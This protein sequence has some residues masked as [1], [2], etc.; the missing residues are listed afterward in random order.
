MVT[1][2]RGTKKPKLLEQINRDFL[3][4]IRGKSKDEAN[5]IWKSAKYNGKWNN[6]DTKN[7][8]EVINK[9]RCSFCTK[10]IDE[11]KIHFNVEHICLKSKYPE[12]A[13]QWD[14]L[15]CS[16]DICNRARG[17]ADIDLDLYIDPTSEK[18]VERYFEYD[19]DGSVKIN[20]GLNGKDRIKAKTMIEKYKLNRNDLKCERRY[21]I[22]ELYSEENFKV[23]FAQDHSKTFMNVWKEY[24]GSLNYE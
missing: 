10:I 9:R 24:E 2:K 20:N 14:N 4:D 18:N 1:L 23:I 15:L 22:K 11:F 17:K 21:F 6:K 19:I 13:F 8:F 16:C 12:K 5:N 7:I 3:K